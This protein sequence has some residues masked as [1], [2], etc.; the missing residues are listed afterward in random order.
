MFLVHNSRH[1]PLGR[2][3]SRSLGAETRVHE[4]PLVGMAASKPRF[5]DSADDE[6]MALRSHDLQ[7]SLL[8][9]RTIKSLIGGIQTRLNIS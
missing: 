8:Y 4:P 9:I 3:L 2:L 7:L 5:G 6:K 1:Y